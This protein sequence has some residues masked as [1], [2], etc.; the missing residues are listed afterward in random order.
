MLSVELGD[1]LKWG[2]QEMDSSFGWKEAS[3]T[4]IGNLKGERKDLGAKISLVLY[5]QMETF[6]RPYICHCFWQNI[7]KWSDYILL[8]CLIKGRVTGQCL[9]CHCIP[10]A[11]YSAWSSGRGQVWHTGEGKAADAWDHLGKE[12]GDRK[13]VTHPEKM[14][15]PWGEH[16]RN[17]LPVAPHCH[18]AFPWALWYHVGAVLLLW[19]CFCFRVIV[20]FVYF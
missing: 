10:R 3:W 6:C 4:E 16:L 5:S 17:E 18:V 20:P 13:A 2:R 8:M 11:G 7:L 14:F 19:Q 15:T 1:Q 9:I 12:R